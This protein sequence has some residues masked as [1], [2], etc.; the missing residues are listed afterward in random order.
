MNFLHHIDIF[1][2]VMKTPSTAGNLDGNSKTRQHG[3]PTL[4]HVSTISIQQLGLN[5]Y[6]IMMHSTEI[7]CQSNRKDF[8]SLFCS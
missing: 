4:I 5:M 3:A 7:Y 1:W 6:N 8:P 2:Y